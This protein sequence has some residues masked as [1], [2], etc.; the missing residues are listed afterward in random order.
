MLITSSHSVSLTHVLKVTVP[1]QHR[2]S[3][4]GVNS[5][6]G[7]WQLEC[8][9]GMHHLVYAAAFFLA[10][11]K[12]THEIGES[13]IA[14]SILI[15]KTLYLNRGAARVGYLHPIGIH[16]YHHPRATDVEVLMNQRIGQQLA[17][18]LLR[19]HTHFLADGLFHHS[20]HGSR[21]A[22]TAN[23]TFKPHRIASLTLSIKPGP[24]LVDAF[25]Y[26][27]PWSLTLNSK[28]EGR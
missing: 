3:S 26:H 28:A 12:A 22:H 15:D 9:C 5:K 20:I 19:E 13:F 23:Q 1:E 2:C 17:Q 25:V 7:R 4:K 24:E 6:I 8:L 11:T 18:S 10:N 27:Q 21:I 14:R 16:F